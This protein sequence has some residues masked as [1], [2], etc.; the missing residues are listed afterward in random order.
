MHIRRSRLFSFVPSC[1]SSSS[2][3]IAT[4]IAL[5][6]LSVPGVSAAQGASRTAR[7]TADAGAE[8]R[9]QTNQVNAPGDFQ[10]P[11]TIAAANVGTGTAATTATA[12]TTE[13]RGSGGPAPD[14]ITGPIGPGDAA[15]LIRAQMPRLRPCYDRARATRPTL[16]GRVEVR[17]TIA[18]DGRVTHATAAG[19][20]EAPEVATCIADVLRQTVFPQP[21]GGSLQIVY[22]LVFAPEPASVAPARGRSRGRTAARPAT[23]SR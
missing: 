9:I 20:P 21:E 5:V 8:I 3:V 18:R 10:G 16:A 4:T 19:L 1:R 13:L 7:A 23:R 15:R 6:S 2:F 17:L 22:P 12:P 11:R 14:A